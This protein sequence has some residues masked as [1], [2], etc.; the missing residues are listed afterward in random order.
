VSLPPE[1]ADRLLALAEMPPFDGNKSK[2]VAFAIDALHMMMDKASPTGLAPTSGAAVV[3][4]YVTQ[5][6]S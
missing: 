5:R 1:V 2:A 3:D 4:F 6:L